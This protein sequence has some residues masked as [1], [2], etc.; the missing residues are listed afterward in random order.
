MIWRGAG[1][2]RIFL[3]TL[4]LFLISCHKASVQTS[5]VKL[6]PKLGQFTAGSTF[7]VDADV[8]MSLDELLGMSELVVAGTV[9]SVSLARLTD[10][11]NS[12]SAV[13]SDF[14]FAVDKVLT[15]APGS[16]NKKLKRVLVSQLGGRYEGHLSSPVG[17]SLL[18]QG[19]RSV[20]FLARDTRAGE[21][22]ISGF[23]RYVVVG[24]WSGNFRVEQSGRIRVSRKSSPGLCV[25]DWM[26]ENDFRAVVISAAE[27]RS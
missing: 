11:A 6:D 24:V 25:Y 10:K 2:T 14:V 8:P 1:R 21:P 7:E 16:A 5:A 22:I 20:L 12:T 9:E 26:P 13:E 18:A 17:Y 3:S 23:S 15:T 19:D 4:A 27:R